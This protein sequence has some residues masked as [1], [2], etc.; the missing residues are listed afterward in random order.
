M[1][2]GE[3]DGKLVVIDDW[4]PQWDKPINQ[5]LY[6]PTGVSASEYA[7]LIGVEVKYYCDG[8]YFTRS[9]YISTNGVRIILENAGK[10]KPIKSD[11]KP[12]PKSRGFKEY[13]YGAWHKN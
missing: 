2:I 11:L 4:I 6:Y 3:L 7:H 12:I 5:R 8:V 10:T 13:R 9:N 1:E